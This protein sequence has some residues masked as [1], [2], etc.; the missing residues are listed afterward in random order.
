MAIIAHYI[1]EQLAGSS[2]VT[3]SSLGGNLP[4]V[5]G[6]L[7]LSNTG[8]VSKGAVKRFR[9]AKQWL[10]SI[11]TSV[12]DAVRSGQCHLEAFEQL[13]LFLSF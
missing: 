13:T 7:E 9:D 8:F 1:S 6:S 10:C 3:V 11:W 12:D 4:L 5:L 2:F